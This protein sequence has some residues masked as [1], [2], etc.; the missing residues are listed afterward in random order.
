MKKATCAEYKNSAAC[1][2]NAIDGTFCVWNAETSV[3][4]NLAVNATCTNIT[5]IGLTAEYC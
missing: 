5:G 4:A 2:M 3:C 1:L